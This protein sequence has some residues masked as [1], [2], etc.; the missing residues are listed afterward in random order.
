MRRW[1]TRQP[2]HRKLVVVAL[3]VTTGA[4]VIANT[5]LVLLDLWRYRA[6]ARDEAISTARVI[7]EN[8]AAAVAF[9]DVDVARSS[10]ESVRVRPTVRRACLFLPDKTLFAAFARSP[11]FA[12]PSSQPSPQVSGC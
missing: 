1:F 8:T 4:L 6:S 12:C 10:L 3:L 7:G 5:G 2:I 9:K 11:E